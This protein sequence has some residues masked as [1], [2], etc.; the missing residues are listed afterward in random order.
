MQKRNSLR[1]IWEL[2][3]FGGVTARN[4][5]LVASP[6][7]FSSHAAVSMAEFRHCRCST[8][9]RL[10]C[11]H[12]DFHSSFSE[13][14]PLDVSGHSTKLNSGRHPLL[15]SAAFQKD[16]DLIIRLWNTSPHLLLNTTSTG[17]Q[18]KMSGLQSCAA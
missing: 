18:Y 1:N 8:N 6:G 12:K 14:K 9:R 5:T 13:P 7:S 16:S 3:R 17:L 11:Q 10:G 4:D 15:H 2:S